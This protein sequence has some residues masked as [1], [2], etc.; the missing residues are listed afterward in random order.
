MS[1]DRIPLFSRAAIR[2]LIL[3]LIV[4]QFLAVTVGMADTVMVASVGEAAVSGISIVDTLNILLIN[5]F[6]ALATGGAVVASQYLGRKDEKTACLASNQLILVGLL[7][8]S[9]IAALALVFNRQILTGI[10]GNIEVQVMDYARTYF[11]LTALSFPFL[12]VY[13]GCAAICRSMGNSQIS[14]K[15][16]ALMNAINIVGNAVLIFGFHMKVEGAAISTLTSRVVASVIMVMIVRNPRLQLHI[17]A[18][19]RLGYNRR[20]IGEIL[21]I[22]VPVAVENGLFQGG[23]LLVAGLVSSFGTVSIAANAV[24][25]TIASFQVIP[26]SAISLAMVTVVGQAVG[27]RR[28][29]EARKY[30]LKL[31]GTAMLAHLAICL[32]MTLCLPQIIGFYGMSAETTR[33]A[34]LVSLIHGISCVVIWAPSFALPNALRAADDVKFVMLVTLCSMGFC[35]IVMSYVLGRY[36]G[37]GLVGVWTAMI[38]DWVLRACIFGWRFFSGGWLKKQKRLEQIL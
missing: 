13:N 30:A 33:L 36:F 18:R 2:R 1:G 22:G 24:A 5:V 9:V 38:L 3:P 4:E 34:Y 7:L 27:A 35:R 28:Y 25:G 37:M 26:G 8:S 6:S 32:P 31:C 21:H 17:D 16:S 19:L 15:V 10:Y 11:Y 12:A 29:E 20:L 23:K 14:M